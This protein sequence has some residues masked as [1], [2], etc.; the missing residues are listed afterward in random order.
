[1]PKTLTRERVDVWVFAVWPFAREESLFRF[2]FF[3][4]ENVR[5]SLVQ[6]GESHLCTPRLYSIFLRPYPP[7]TYAS[8]ARRH[9]YIIIC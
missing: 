1:M 8:I 6:P 7:L 3:G 5:V 9:Y 4:N 2:Y